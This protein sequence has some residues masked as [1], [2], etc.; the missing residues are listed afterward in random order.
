MKWFSSELFRVCQEGPPSVKSGLSSHDYPSD[1]PHTLLDHCL[2]STFSPR[3]RP[4]HLLAKMS[5]TADTLNIEK[6]VLINWLVLSPA[7]HMA[8]NIIWQPLQKIWR[9][10]ILDLVLK[11]KPRK[12]PVI[13]QVSRQVFQFID[14]SHF[15]D[16]ARFLCGIC[17]AS[18]PIHFIWGLCL[19]G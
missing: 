18:A 8:G 11:R 13:H 17:L 5:M 6:P 2:Q 4:H 1:F 10:V 9:V 16:F 19:T 15:S 7:Q 12:F 14:L 3:A